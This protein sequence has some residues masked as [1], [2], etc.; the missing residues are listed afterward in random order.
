MFDKICTKENLFFLV[1]IVTVIFCINI[2]NLLSAFQH[3]YFV[4]DQDPYMQMV[5]TSNLIKHHAWYLTT[6]SRVNAPFSADVHYWTHAMNALLILGVFFMSYFTSVSKALYF[7]SY[8]LPILFNGIA[9]IGMLW[10]TKIW[11]PSPTQKFFTLIAFLVNPFVHF[12][13]TPL[14]VDYNFLLN[15]IAIF[16]WGGLLRMIISPKIKWATITAVLAALGIWTSIAFTIPLLIG[17]ILIWIAQ[18]KHKIE[19]LLFM[20]FMAMLCGM[21]ALILLVEHQHFWTVSYDVVSIAY[22]TFFLF[23]FLGSIFY[24]LYFTS[25][26]GSLTKRILFTLILLLLIGFIMNSLFPGF[27]KGPYNQVDPYLMKHFF[28][29]LTE[30]ATPF[31]IGNSFALSIFAYFFIAAGFYYYAYLTHKENIPMA[32]SILL[33]AATIMTGLTVYMSRW[34]EFATPLNILCVSFFAASFDCNKIKQLLFI[35]LMALLPLAIASIKDTVESDSRK[36]REQFNQMLLDGFF[37]QSSFK[38]E[39]IIFAHSNYGPLLLYYT[40]FSVV[41]TNDHHNLEGVRDTF[42]FFTENKQNA[43]KMLHKRNIHLVLLCKLERQPSFELNEKNG[44]QP[45]F[46]PTKY[47]L[48]QLYRVM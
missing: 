27:F 19:P 13:F 2:D 37:E 44:L 46:L 38:N 1:L 5:I 39:K 10:T 32:Q 22:L 28:P 21:T 34:A 31:R 12:I 35:I 17:F 43:K 3:H 15:T 30:S 18:I 33:F 36:C 8:I 48:W 4:Y 26:A 11:K 47:S 42:N 16:Y 25:A 20:I 45:I 23:I 24:N 7:W 29:I 41:A 9:A 6:S 14:R 40:H